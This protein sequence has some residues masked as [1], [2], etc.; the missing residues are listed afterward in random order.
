MDPS[1]VRLFCGHFHPVIF[2]E[3]FSI[4]YPFLQVTSPCSFHYI[5]QTSNVSPTWIVLKQRISLAKLPFCQLEILTPFP[6]LQITPLR[7]FPKNPW[8]RGT[9]THIYVTDSWFGCGFRFQKKGAK[10]LATWT[11]WNG[12]WSEPRWSSKQTFSV[13]YTLGPQKKHG[14][15]KGFFFSPQVIWV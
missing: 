9:T 12:L 7:N 6:C 2:E 5:W 3:N 1:C 11:G 15:M 13:L 10:Q 4:N 8:S 14:K